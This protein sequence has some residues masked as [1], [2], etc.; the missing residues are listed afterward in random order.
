M[1]QYPNDRPV[2]Y[3]KRFD[4][5]SDVLPK[6]RT[7]T[8]NRGLRQDEIYQ[9]V[10]WRRLFKKRLQTS[11]VI[12]PLPSSVNLTECYTVSV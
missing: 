12:S 6:P 10:L 9:L 4:S 3:S 7:I 11:S 1:E 8:E 5:E 2:H